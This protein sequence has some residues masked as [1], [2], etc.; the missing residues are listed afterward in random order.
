M[1]ISMIVWTIIL[2]IIFRFLTKYILPI[3]RMTRMASGRLREMHGNM[4]NANQQPQQPEV[5]K[6]TTAPRPNKNDY[7]DY[8]EIK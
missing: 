5:K 3:V 4:N 7:I 6:T 8:E 2:F 1:S